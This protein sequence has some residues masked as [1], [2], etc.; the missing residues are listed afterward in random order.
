MRKETT[1]NDHLDEEN[2]STSVVESSKTAEQFSHVKTV[3]E[4]ATSILAAWHRSF[5]GVIEAGRLWDH[6]KA[7][8]SKK[9]LAELKAETKFSD[10]TIS[11]LISVAKNPRITNQK[12]RTFLPSSYGT[13][14]ELTHLSDAEFEAAFKDGAL[15]PDIQREEVMALRGKQHSSRARAKA[16][17]KVLFT[18]L[19]TKDKIEPSDLPLVK[20]AVLSLL[21]CPSVTVKESPLWKRLA[22]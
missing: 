2:S 4:F 12:Y 17:G 21:D 11:K 10:T 14:Y 15:R 13:L 1:D 20:T 5:D 8:L 16:T 22:K 19:L 7:T 6:A 3:A 18:I 9:E